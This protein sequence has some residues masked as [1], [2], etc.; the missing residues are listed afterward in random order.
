MEAEEDSGI[1]ARI[2]TNIDL[3]HLAAILDYAL[4]AARDILTNGLQ[5]YPRD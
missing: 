3:F 5:C 2:A 1:I 4:A